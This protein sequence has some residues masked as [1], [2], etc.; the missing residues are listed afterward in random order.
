[1][2]RKCFYQH[3]CSECYNENAISWWDADNPNY[4][5]VNSSWFYCMSCLKKILKLDPK[6]WNATFRK[7]TKTFLDWYDRA[8]NLKMN[9]TEIREMLRG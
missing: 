1:M 3:V 8:P 4:T 5:E 9:T 7:D 2:M 6:E